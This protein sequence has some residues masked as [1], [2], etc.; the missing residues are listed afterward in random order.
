MEPLATKAYTI[1]YHET[2]AQF[3]QLQ[4]LSIDSFEV[5]AEKISEIQGILHRIKGGAGFFGLPQL[6]Q[7]AA[8]LEALSR[9]G[10]PEIRGKI[11]EFQRLVSELGDRIDAMP[12][13]R[14]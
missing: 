11:E 6:S 10:L 5:S 9:R 2:K 3:A 12:A 8:A 14:N 1:F 7:A 13:P 4:T